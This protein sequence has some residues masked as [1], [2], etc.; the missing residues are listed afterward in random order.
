MDSP[1]V[2]PLVMVDSLGLPARSAN[3]KAMWDG[4]GPQYGPQPSIKMSDLSF[5]TPLSK[6]IFYRSS[7]RCAFSCFLSCLG[8]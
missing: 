2:A 5:F 8:V 4:K 7:I 1:A 6:C 3:A